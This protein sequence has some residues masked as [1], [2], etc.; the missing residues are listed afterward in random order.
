M[1]AGFWKWAICCPPSPQNNVA[2][3]K[4]VTRIKH[5]LAIVRERKRH[6]PAQQF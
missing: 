6:I 1:A 5:F 4:G 3:P 2:V